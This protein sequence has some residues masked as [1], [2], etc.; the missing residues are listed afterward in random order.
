MTTL[1]QIQGIYG[2]RMGEAYAHRIHDCEISFVYLELRN[3]VMCNSHF[4][5]VVLTSKTL[6]II[7]S[8]IYNARYN[9]L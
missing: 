3:T 5:V 4:V 2:E 6:P 9:A 7:A 1:D 8:Y